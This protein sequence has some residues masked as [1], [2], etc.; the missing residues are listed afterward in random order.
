MYFYTA[1]RVRF[2]EVKY[3]FSNN[4]ETNCKQKNITDMQTK[5]QV[6]QKRRNREAGVASNED[7]GIE[8]T[9]QADKHP[10]QVEDEL[11]KNGGTEDISNLYDGGERE[12][13]NQTKVSVN[14]ISWNFLNTQ[15]LTSGKKRNI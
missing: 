13:L 4:K 12:K 5:R 1:L 7:G 2:V 9:N 3:R 15:K 8:K 6:E 10:S 11:N 14:I